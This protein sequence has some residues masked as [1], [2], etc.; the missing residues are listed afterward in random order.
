MKAAIFLLIVCFAGFRNVAAQE[1]KIPEAKFLK[2]TKKIPTGLAFKNGKLSAK[3]GYTA[4]FDEKRNIL[5][6]ARANNNNG[7]T[8]SI[9]CYCQG[10]LGQRPCAVVASGDGSFSCATCK[11]DKPCS[12]V[13]GTQA[14]AA[15]VGNDVTVDDKGNKIKWAILELPIS[16]KK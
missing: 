2:T 1:V 6:I 16:G 11:E 15:A 5:S 7:G 14:T 13:F 8:V 9:T 3:D 4:T 10:W 12:V